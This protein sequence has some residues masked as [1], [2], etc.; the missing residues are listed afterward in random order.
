MLWGLTTLYPQLFY[1][2]A[3][4]Q[5]DRSI[6]FAV[7]TDKNNSTTTCTCN[8]SYTVILYPV[9]AVAWVT[10]VQSRYIQARMHACTH[11]PTFMH[12]Y[13]HETLFYILK[14]C[15]GVVKQVFLVIM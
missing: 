5:W 10:I 7:L 3:W 9:V 11:T 8:H 12:V 6:I 13:L 2:D 15:E 14:A 1:S 4:F